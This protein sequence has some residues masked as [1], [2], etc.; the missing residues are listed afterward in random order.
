MKTS[1]GENKPHLDDTSFA[2]QQSSTL[3]MKEILGDEVTNTL[4]SR[5]DLM[6]PGYRFGE[7]QNANPGLE[8]NSL[9]SSLEDMFGEQ[10]GSGLTLQ[11]GRAC[12]KYLIQACGDSLGFSSMSF[13]LLS[14]SRKIEVGSQSL[15]D[16]FTKTTSHSFHW[17]ENEE[18]YTWHITYDHTDPCQSIPGPICM[19]IAGLLQETFYWMSAGQVYR[20]EETC[21]H[22][23]GKQACTIRIYRKPIA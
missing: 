22:A 5:N 10:A 23:P 17:E 8:I 20:V 13:R 9:Q 19:F 21:C 11:I 18:W 4:F 16:F 14:L 15:V 6:K 2:M 3:A 12:F 7:S 1:L